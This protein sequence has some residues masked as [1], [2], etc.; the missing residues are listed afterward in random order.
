GD[1]RSEQA[2]EVEIVPLEH[3]TERRSRD[4]LDVR[5]LEL[6]VGGCGSGHVVHPSPL[7]ALTVPRLRK[8]RNPFPFFPLDGGKGFNLLTSPRAPAALRPGLAGPGRRPV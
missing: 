4:D 2:V 6:R 1:D 5:T 3:R 8:P 7:V